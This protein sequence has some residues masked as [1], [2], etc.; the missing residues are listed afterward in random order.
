MV[1]VLAHSFLMESPSKL[2]V[3]RTGIKAWISSISGLWFPW[4][5]YMF[6]E[7]RFDLGTFDSGERSLPFGLLVISS[8]RAIQQ[9][10]KVIFK[11]LFMALHSVAYVTFSLYPKKIDITEQI[12]SFII[13]FIA[14]LRFSLELSKIYFIGLYRTLN[15]ILI[16]CMVGQIL[17]VN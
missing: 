1:S 17:A 14:N 6:F 15:I 9:A 12:I 11:S 2:L 5:I 4:P 10:Q 13:F 8:D 7:M 16:S 3:T